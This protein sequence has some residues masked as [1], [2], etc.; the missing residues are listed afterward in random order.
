MAPMCKT[1]MVRPWCA[2]SSRLTT[3]DKGYFGVLPRPS[4]VSGDAIVDFNRGKGGKVKF[5]TDLSKCKKNETG[6]SWNVTGPAGPQGEQG[7]PGADGAKGAT[8]ETGPQGPK[9][10]TGGAGTPVVLDADGKQIGVFLGC[11]SY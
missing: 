5:V 11:A 2:F 6:V 1:A 10:D 7:L 4:R 8:G 9:G 3:W